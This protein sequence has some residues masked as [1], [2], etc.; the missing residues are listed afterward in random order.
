M[1]DRCSSPDH[2]TEDEPTS[3]PLRSVA[4]LLAEHWALHATDITPLEGGMNSLTWE[5]RSQSNRWVAKAVP[6][7]AEDAFVFGLELATR[8]EETGIPAGAPVATADGRSVVPFGRRTMALL[9]WVEG[10]GLAGE[11]HTELDVMGTTLARAHRALGLQ[12]G[13]ATAPTGLYLPSEHL[14]V[15]PWLRPVITKVMARLEELDLRSLTWGP[16]HGDLAADVFRLDQVSG[17]CGMIDWSGAGIWPRAYDLAAL[18]M[19]QGAHAMRPLIDAYAAGG[20]LTHDEIERALH[21]LLDYRWAGQA[22]YFAGRIARGDLTGIDGPEVN[23]AGLEA[24][25]RWFTDHTDD[26]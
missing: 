5:V 24:A 25:R 4:R 9:R 13:T 7:E 11:S 2:T 14:D 16:V 17:V 18:V 3:R 12:D 1:A 22:V 23:E 6:P 8:L 15:R 19:Y 10:R 26:H 21:P 20:A